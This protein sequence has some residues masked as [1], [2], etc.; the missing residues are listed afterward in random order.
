[1]EK[2]KL[3]EKLFDV[4]VENVNINKGLLMNGLNHFDSSYSALDAELSSW[5]DKFVAAFVTE[6]GVHRIVWTRF[7]A[8]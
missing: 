2:R 6:L 8:C 5:N 4:F 1:M 7:R 3:I